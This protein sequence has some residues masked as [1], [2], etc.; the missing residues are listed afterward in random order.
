MGEG[1]VGE[2]LDTGKDGGLIR[3]RKMAMPDKENPGQFV[4]IGFVGEID[5]IVTN[6]ANPFQ[7]GDPI[8]FA[9]RDVLD[10]RQN[11]NR[12]PL[13]LV[14]SVRS[15]F[16]DRLGDVPAFLERATRGL[17]FLRP[18]DRG[19]LRAIATAALGELRDAGLVVSDVDDLT[20][21]IIWKLTP[22]GTARARAWLGASGAYR[23]WGL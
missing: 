18:L 9:P 19:G 6:P 13:R 12:A 14:A 2:R 7:L 3:A 15:D 10:M 11:S 4:D 16:L 8:C 22:A 1:T 21:D 23:G 5:A 17:M 20:D